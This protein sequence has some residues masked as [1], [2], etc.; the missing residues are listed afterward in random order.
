MNAG[1]IGGVAGALLGVAGGI[2]GTWASI[3]NTRGP[4]ERA[5][6]VRASLWCWLLGV[7]FLAG[8]LLLPKPWGVLM[9]IPYAVVLP[10]GIRHV[11]RRQAELQAE[12]ARAG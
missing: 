9:W 1:L 6:M 5:F 2:I 8:L 4:R 10:L 11:N 3:R 7:L 12:D